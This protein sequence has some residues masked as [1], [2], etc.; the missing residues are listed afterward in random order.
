MWFDGAKTNV[1]LIKSTRVNKSMVFTT[2]SDFM[3]SKVNYKLGAPL[4]FFFENYRPK[5]I[6]RNFN[7][8]Y[9]EAL[10]YFKC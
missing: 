6:H 5:K 3:Y 7:N 1:S 2:K 4:R 10:S 9:I 8:F